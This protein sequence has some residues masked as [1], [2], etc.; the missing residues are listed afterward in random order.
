MAAG[1]VPYHVGP[2]GKGVGA[3]SAA[4]SHAACAQH[5]WIACL[6]RVRTICSP[7]HR[8]S[9]LKSTDHL[10]SSAQ[11]YM[12]SV[13]RRAHEQTPASGAVLIVHLFF[14]SPVRDREL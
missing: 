3:R 12:H 8:P 1:R 10:F 2:T 6:W 13:S 5:V 4:I 11:T 7:E 14:L 9:V